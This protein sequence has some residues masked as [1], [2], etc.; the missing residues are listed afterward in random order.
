MTDSIEK[1]RNGVRTKL[2]HDTRTREK[3]RSTQLINRLQKHILTYP[4]K[5]TY[6]KDLMTQSQVT[7]ALGLI[8]KTLPDLHNIEGAIEVD[9]SGEVKHK[10]EHSVKDDLASNFNE[11]QDKF[12]S[13]EDIQH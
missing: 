5:K 11:W 9:N 6:K 4:D 2:T 13:E 8:K 1:P 12:S 10:H 3:I 7:A